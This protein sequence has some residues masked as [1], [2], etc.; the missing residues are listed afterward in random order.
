MAEHIEVPH[1]VALIYRVVGDTHVFSSK[2]I[3][4][5][6]HVGCHDREEA[7]H[8][9]LG[10]LNEHV[11]HTYGCPVTYSCAMTYEQFSEHLAREDDFTANFLEVTLDQAA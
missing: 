8:G 11:S 2:G 5:L 7:F 6:V 9:V 3:K 10:A 4:G 1:S